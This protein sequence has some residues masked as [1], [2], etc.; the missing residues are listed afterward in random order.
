MHSL[1]PSF[2][3]LYSKVQAEV[4]IPGGTYWRP[5]QVPTEGGVAGLH[6]HTSSVTLKAQKGKAH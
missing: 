6:D 2:F 5:F 4:A 3:I 1:V